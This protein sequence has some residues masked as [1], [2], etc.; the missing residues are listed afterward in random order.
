MAKENS[1]EKE[2]EKESADQGEE[3][4]VFLEWKAPERSFSKKGKKYFQNLFAILFILAAAA[5]F[6]KEFLLAGVLVVFGFL[7]YVL[8]TVPPGETEYQITRHGIRT[9]GHDYPWDEL[10]DFWF[11]EG[12][13]GTILNI[14]TKH[15]FPGRLFLQLKGV[16][17]KKVAAVIKTFIPE[18]ERPPEDIAAR[19]SSEVSRRVKLE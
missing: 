7:R 17:R 4:K 18:R 14:D 13:S 2:T 9:H 11:S 15:F 19:V 10:K 6:F 5:V 8:G 1:K 3:K 16:N 12:A